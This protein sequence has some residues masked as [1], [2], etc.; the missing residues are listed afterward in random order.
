MRTRLLSF[1]GICVAAALLWVAV[2]VGQPPADPTDKNTPDAP[3]LPR[4]EPIAPRADLPSITVPITPVAPRVEPPQNIDQLLNAL[5]D[6]RAKK[7]E[8]E[9]QEQATVKALRERVM[10]QKQRFAALGINVEEAPPRP[11]PPQVA[12]RD[13]PPPKDG[14]PPKP[15]DKN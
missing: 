5:T 11:T 6:I 15:V 3:T 4:L 10:E 14:P 8:L 7:A 1:A 12:P 13:E 2:S 9:K